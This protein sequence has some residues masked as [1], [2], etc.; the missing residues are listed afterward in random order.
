[1]NDST[2]SHLSLIQSVISR[3]A[4]NSFALKGW[5]VTVSAA[6]LGLAARD[7][8]SGFA[9]VALYP[10]LAFWGLD[11]Y[12]LRQERRFRAL[13]DAVRTGATREPLSMDPSGCDASVDKWS[14]TIWSGSVVGLHVP[15]VAAIVAV[16]IYS[17]LR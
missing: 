2:L 9:V 13:Y 12:Y 8:N 15:V 16:L 17:R 1:M 3:L 11:A 10:A 6:L 4:S 14:A 5:S 7:A